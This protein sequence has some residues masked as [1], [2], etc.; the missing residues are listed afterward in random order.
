MRKILVIFFTMLISIFAF[1]MNGYVVKVSD[2]D[3]FVMSSYG[4]RVKNI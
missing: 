4:K 2:G 1:S 3:S